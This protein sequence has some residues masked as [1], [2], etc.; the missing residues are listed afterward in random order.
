MNTPVSFEVAKIVLNKGFDKECNQY[1]NLI[2]YGEE[3]IVEDRINMDSVDFMY[4]PTIS[5]MVMWLYEKYGI[6][7]SVYMLDKGEFHWETEF[8][9]EDIG[10]R[11]PNYYKTP[12]EAYEAAIDYVLNNLI[13]PK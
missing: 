4:A 5:D 13:Q 1:W 8:N 10:S 3:W 11:Y 12:A 6:W 7:I 2:E 9:S